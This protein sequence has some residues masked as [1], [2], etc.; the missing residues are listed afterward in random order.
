MGAKGLEPEGNDL[1]NAKKVVKIP[2]HEHCYM[3]LCKNIKICYLSF[4]KILMNY[5][6]L[7]TSDQ[8]LLSCSGALV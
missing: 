1:K 5:T 3:C 8:I 6:R 4:A 7:S 2:G